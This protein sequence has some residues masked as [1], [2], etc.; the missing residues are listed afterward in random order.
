MWRFEKHHLPAAACSSSS[1]TGCC[2]SSAA[3]TQRDLVVVGDEY[4]ARDAPVGRIGDLAGVALALARSSPS[5]WAA[6]C[7]SRKFADSGWKSRSPIAITPFEN[8]ATTVP[9]ISG[10][11]FWY[12]LYR[13]PRSI[14]ATLRLRR[15]HLEAVAREIDV[16]GRRR[17]PRSRGSR[18]SP[19]RTAC[20]GP[21]PACRALR[22]RSAAR[23][24]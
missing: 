17:A 3:V 15:R 2:G 24:G 22:R 6:T 9:T 4:R 5:G 16:V 21:R 13:S 11:G 7:E 23:R 14:S 20:C 8:G 12:G 1:D 19:R 10:R 18:R